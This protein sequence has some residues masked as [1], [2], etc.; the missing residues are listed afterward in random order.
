MAMRH[1][2]PPD[3]HATR[4][5][6]L[7]IENDSRVYHQAYLPAVENLKK[8]AAKG[9]YDHLLAAKL[10][11]YTA[12]HGAKAYAKE[13]GGTWNTM[14]NPATR[15]AVARELRD[16]F[17]GEYGSLIKTVAQPPIS[18]AAIRFEKKLKKHLR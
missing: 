11:E 14:F 15:R 9:K 6:V 13:F 4:E 18:L 2:P 12:E 8:K 17:E 10:F 16:N 1:M 7:Y 5:L 3:D